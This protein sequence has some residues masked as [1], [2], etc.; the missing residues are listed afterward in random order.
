ELER[1]IRKDAK[2]DV[3]KFIG[4]L[5]ETLKIQFGAELERIDAK[6]NIA[7]FKAKQNALRNIDRGL[8]PTKSLLQYE[9]DLQRIAETIPS[10]NRGGSTPKQGG[11]AGEK[12]DA[13]TK[14]R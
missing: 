13:L 3:D 2:I 14:V 5:N 4:T 9:N 7:L 11:P 10:S 6:V 8:S 12:I 1:K